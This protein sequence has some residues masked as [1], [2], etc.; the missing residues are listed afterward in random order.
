LLVAEIIIYY[1]P[2]KEAAVARVTSSQAPV[3][4]D[5]EEEGIISAPLLKGREEGSS[6]NHPAQY[7]TD[8]ETPPTDVQTT[9][10]SNAAAVSNGE[11]VTSTSS[12]DKSSA[13]V[14]NAIGVSL[15]VV[16]AT[17]TTLIF[18]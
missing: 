1:L 6:T 14:V 11:N 5:R 13:L 2:S 12:G 16:A 18:S 9:S 8:Q 4:Q 10:S 7:G 17:I 15:A 3:M